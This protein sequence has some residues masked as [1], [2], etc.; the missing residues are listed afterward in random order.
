MKHEEIKSPIYHLTRRD[1]I[2]TTTMAGIAAG[3]T[4]ATHETGPAPQ[5]KSAQLGASTARKPQRHHGLHYTEPARVWDEAM[6]LGNGLLRRR[7]SP[8]TR[9]R[10][11]GTTP[12][13]DRQ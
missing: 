13:R 11:R 12:G 9:W 3:C 4:T 5:A 8:T 10:W 6:P 2:V 1:F 7:R